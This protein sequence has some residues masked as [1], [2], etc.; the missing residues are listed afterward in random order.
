M[1]KLIVVL[2]TLGSVVPLRAQGG[3]GDLG[4]GF[5]VG[6]VTGPTLKYFV[7]QN[8]ALDI[9]LGFSSDFKA[10]GDFIWH[11]WDVFP[12]PQKGRFAGMLGVGPR[13]EER[14]RGDDEFGIRVMGGVGYWMEPYPIEIFAALGPWFIFSPDTDTEIASHLLENAVHHSP[15]EAPVNVAVEVAGPMARVTVSDEGPGI[16]P[17]DRERVFAARVVGGDP[18]AIGEASGE[19]AHDRTLPA[20][21]VAPAAEDD[22]EPARGELSSRREDA[23][24]GVWGVGVVDDHGRLR[25]AHALEA[26]AHGL[27]VANA[28]FDRGDG[29]SDDERRADRAEPVVEVRQAEKSRVDAD[30][31]VRRD[32]GAAQAIDGDGEIVGGPHIGAFSERECGCA[33]VARE[34]AAAVFVVD[35]DDGRLPRAVDLIEEDALRGEVVIEVSVK[36]EVLAREVCE[37]SG[38]ETDAVRALEREGM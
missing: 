15:P 11:G 9:G 5:V 29:N 3:A 28:R 24:Q 4:L 38:G 26:P 19:L 18:H 12:R 6:D 20:V 23:L 13:Y 21:P 34:A 16:P 1:K 27:Q 32:D 31:S 22:A 25:I 10:Y 14:D 8:T 33:E 35:V 30:V 2:F 37:D 7:G 17:E 36:V